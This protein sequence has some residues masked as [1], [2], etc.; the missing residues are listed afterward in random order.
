VVITDGREQ[1]LK[2][3]GPGHVLGIEALNGEASPVTVTTVTQIAACRVPIGV[4]GQIVARDPSIALRMVAFLNRELVRT[5]NA[6]RNLGILSAQER[7]ACFILSLLPAH[8]HPDDGI[9]IPLTRTDVARMLGLRPET[10]SRALS[11]IKRL[12]LLHESGRCF[13]VPDPEGLRALVGLSAT[14][15]L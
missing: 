4:M 5:G 3:G 6:V 14:D 2:L 12:G 11:G 8:C 1:I 13:F 10:F 15:S 7:V 9:R